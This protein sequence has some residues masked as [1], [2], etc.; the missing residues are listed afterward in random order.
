MLR[1][2]MTKEEWERKLEA[3]T[4][5]ILDQWGDELAKGE[6]RDD[7]LAEALRSVLLNQDEVSPMGRA[8]T[9]AVSELLDAIKA[10]QLPMLTR[11]LLTVPFY[12]DP[13]IEMADAEAQENLE[14]A[15]EAEVIK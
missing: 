5:R 8:C 15:I 11:A 7:V 10:G 14:R 3:E 12:S 1:S 9:E 2:R 13:L 4:D 6:A